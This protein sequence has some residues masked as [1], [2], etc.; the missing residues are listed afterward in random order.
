LSFLYPST[1]RFIIEDYPDDEPCPSALF[2]G[3][4]EMRP[5]H[6]VV[7]QCADHARVI[8]VYIPEKDKWIN[9]RIRKDK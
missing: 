8:T 2:M 5:C 3:F 9:N 4:I 7:S 1:P 6:V